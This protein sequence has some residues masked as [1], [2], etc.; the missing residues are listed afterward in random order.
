MTTRKMADAISVATGIDRR[1]VRIVLAT[2]AEILR[3]AAIQQKEVVFSGLFRLTPVL[4]EM[5]IPTGDGQGGRKKVRRILL[6][7]R[8]VKA[9]RKEL[10]RWTSTP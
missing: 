4:R 8:P 10:A 2:Q 7:V 9:F 1:V 3:A 5:S 6:Q